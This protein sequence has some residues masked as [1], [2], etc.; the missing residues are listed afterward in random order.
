MVLPIL[1]KRASYQALWL[2]RHVSKHIHYNTKSLIFLDHI[3]PL[4]SPFSTVQ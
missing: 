2:V 3:R 4:L 1:L